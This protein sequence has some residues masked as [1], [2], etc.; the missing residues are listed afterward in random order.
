MSFFSES[1]YVGVDVGGSHI[2]CGL[3]DNNGVVLYTLEQHLEDANFINV[4]TLIGMIGNMVQQVQ[5]EFSSGSIVNGN[6]PNANIAT[7]SSMDANSSTTYLPFAPRFTGRQVCGIGIGFPGQTKKGVLVAASNFPNLKNV[8][9][10]ELL[11]NQSRF[12][13]IPIIL[14][15]AF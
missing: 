3:V 10:V 12:A 6:R 13:N 4:S 8:P 2:G 5:A 1:M 9:I 11:Q 14:L 7:S 15:N